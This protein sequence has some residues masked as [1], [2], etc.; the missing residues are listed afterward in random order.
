MKNNEYELGSASAR[1][2]R[3][4]PGGHGGPGGP[5]GAG[6]KAKDFKGIMKQLIHYAKGASAF[7]ILAIIFAMA[8]SILTLMGPDNLS[9]L[10]D[11][12]TAGIMTSIDMDAIY[13]IGVFL[14]CV[15]AL[16][17][18]LSILQGVIMAT[19][20]QGVAKRLRSDIGNKINRLPMKYFSTHSKGD[21]LS[22][23]TNDVD[24]I[25][26]T[27][28]QSVGTLISALTLIIGSVIMMTITNV[29]LTITAI[30]STIFGFVFM[31]TVMKLSQK[32]FKRQQKHLGEINGH[33][34]E[35]YAGHTVV[36]AYN[37][38]EEAT[39]IF[40]T[41][42]E[43]LK[44]SAFRAQAMSGLMMPVMTFIGNLGYV[45]VCIVG[46]LLAM[47]NVISFGVIVA[48]MVYIRLFTQPLGQVAQGMQ[49]LQSGAA[50]AERVFEFLGEMEM[51]DE[52]H[53]RMTLSNVKGNIEFQNVHFGYDSDKIIINDFSASVKAG[54]KIA[55]VGPTGAGKTTMVNL[56]MRFYEMQSGNI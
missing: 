32:Y 53:K 23:V 43:E 2:Q 48:F 27:L 49:N 3:R 7:M 31:M 28:T 34:E 47:N 19:V 26:Q 40:N 37:G 35:M 8:G 17:Y 14:V 45:C 54:E 16:S 33:I 52:S 15:Y 1:P 39:H 21:V 41:I 6:E 20:M 11:E 12:I 4:G 5:M 22:R 25:G 44:D 36:K 46:A 18:V 24:T 30:L 51:S 55:I 38:E 13:K 29:A 10:T 42:N 50:A 56:L 9:R